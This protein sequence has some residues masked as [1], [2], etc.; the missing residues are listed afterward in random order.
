VKG[1]IGAT[2]AELPAF[3]DNC[4]ERVNIMRRYFLYI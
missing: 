2:R 1:D 3:L 4:A